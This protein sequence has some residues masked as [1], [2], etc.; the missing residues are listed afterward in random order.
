MLLCFCG[1][2]SLC[3][4][5]WSGSDPLRCLVVII[6]YFNTRVW[7]HTTTSN[8]LLYYCRSGPQMDQ[9]N[10]NPVKSLHKKIQIKIDYY[11]QAFP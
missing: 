11:K 1:L 9:I 7:S 5:S 10:A 2:G 8:V 4:T 3:D 6:G